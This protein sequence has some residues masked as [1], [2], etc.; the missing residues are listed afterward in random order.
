MKS[1]GPRMRAA[2]AG[3]KTYHGKPCKNCGTT[4]KRTTSG[5]CVKC[6]REA[7]AKHY[8]K[9]KEIIAASGG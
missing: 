7:S 2:M 9:V 5:A 4:E 6:S 1:K 8:K 3:A